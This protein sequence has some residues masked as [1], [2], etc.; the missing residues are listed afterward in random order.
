M[1]PAGLCSYSLL[2]QSAHPVRSRRENLR[3][4]GRTNVGLLWEE[5]GGI[6]NEVLQPEAGGHGRRRVRAGRR[7]DDRPGARA[8]GRD[9]R[10]RRRRMGAGRGLRN[11]DPHG[12]P[13]GRLL[14][15][16]R[17]HLRRAGLAHPAGLVHAH[18]RH[19]SGLHRRLHGEGPGAPE[20]R[21]RRHGLHV[22]L[23]QLPGGGV[24]AGR[25][26]VHRPR[27]PLHRSQHRLLLALYVG[28]LPGGLSS[29]PERGLEDLHRRHPGSQRDHSPRRMDRFRRPR[30]P[31]HLHASA[32]A[33]SHVRGRDGRR[34]RDPDPQHRA[35]DVLRLRLRLRPQ[36]RQHHDQ[37][38]S[39]G[40]QR[41]GSDGVGRR[42]RLRARRR[43]RRHAVRRRARRVGATS[44][45]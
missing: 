30:G 19:Q 20:H 13:S 16:P 39:E 1:V 41:H 42:R 34:R 31:E 28:D 24:P 23:V 14:E 7:P 36:L 37:G 3:R 43:V 32:P 4:V 35:R 33:G 5:Q 45:S 18:E 9:V 29:Q 2:V 22:L 25:L 40:L 44:P 10:Q 11:G 8:H 26:R 15:R 17:H 38:A 21:R 12:R 27:Q 6:E